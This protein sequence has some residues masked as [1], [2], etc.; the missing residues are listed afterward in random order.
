MK[1][2]ILFILV[3]IL[4]FGNLYGQISVTA[5]AGGKKKTTH[6][7]KLDSSKNITTA[8]T[9]YLNDGTKVNGKMKASFSIGFRNPFKAEFSFI[10][11]AGETV[12]VKNIDHI[13]KNDGHVLG[14]SSLRMM[15]Y[16]SIVVETVLLTGLLYVLFVL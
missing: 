8:H 6:V 13:E 16:T 9:A 14:K 5:G 4:A 1:K 12:E 10:S 3:S 15:H 2:S 11:D 7:T